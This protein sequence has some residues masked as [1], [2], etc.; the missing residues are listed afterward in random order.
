M[1]RGNWLTATLHSRSSIHLDRPRPEQPS[2]PF[3]WTGC[4]IVAF[5]RRNTHTIEECI[6]RLW[7][8]HAS[9]TKRPRMQH[10]RNFKSSFVFIYHVIS[11]FRHGTLHRI[12]R[13]PFAAKRVT[14]VTPRHGM[15]P[16]RSTHRSQ[17]NRRAWAPVQEYHYCVTE[18][19]RNVP[20]TF[21]NR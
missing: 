20:R 3:D 13:R 1:Q 15:R 14:D 2:H 8:R 19:H 12:P 16:G 4:R 7:R 5:S 11:I 17:Q 10:R 18:H 6:A 9:A 21:R